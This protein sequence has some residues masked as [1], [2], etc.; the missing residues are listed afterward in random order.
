MIVHTMEHHEVIYKKSFM[1]MFVNTYNE[2]KVYNMINVDIGVYL[3]NRHQIKITS[4]PTTPE[5]TSSHLSPSSHPSP[6]CRPPQ[7]LVCFL[8][9]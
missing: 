5:V 2:D 3:W 7:P 4:M 9:L 8:S 6:P 1:S